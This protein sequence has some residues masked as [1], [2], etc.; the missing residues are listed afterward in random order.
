MATAISKP[1]LPKLLSSSDTEKLRL[2]TLTSQNRKS[3]LTKSLTNSRRPSPPPRRPWIT[4][5][6]ITHLSLIAKTQ[7]LTPPNFSLPEEIQYQLQEEWE[8]IVHDSFERFRKEM[9]CEECGDMIEWCGDEGVKWFLEG[10]RDEMDGWCAWEVDER[11]VE[12]WDGGFEKMVPLLRGR[13]VRGC[14]LLEQ[15]Q[16]Q[17]EEQDHGGVGGEE[18]EGG[19]VGL[20]VEEK[21]EEGNIEGL[22]AL[23]LMGGEGFTAHGFVRHRSPLWGSVVDEPLDEDTAREGSLVGDPGDQNSVNEEFESSVR[24]QESIAEDEEITITAEVEDVQAS[25]S[26]ETFDIKEPSTTIGGQPDQFIIDML[27]AP[28]KDESEDGSSGEIDEADQQSGGD[29]E[30][31]VFADSNTDAESDDESSLF[32]WPSDG[33]EIDEPIEP[34]PMYE[35]KAPGS[36]SQET[37]F[38]GC[39]IEDHQRF[40]LGNTM[41][42]DEPRES[43]SENEADNKEDSDSEDLENDQRETG[44]DVCEDLDQGVEVQGYHEKS[45]DAQ[46]EDGTGICRVVDQGAEEV[47]SVGGDADD[48]ES[49]EVLDDSDS[50]RDIRM[51]ENT[52]INDADTEHEESNEEEYDSQTH[53][54]VLTDGPAKVSSPGDPDSEVEVLVENS[55]GYEYE[56]EQ[57]VPIGYGAQF[58]GVREYQGDESDESEEE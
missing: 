47:E 22:E 17:Q 26:S 46:M 35:V 31:E 58:Q 57:N 40:P 50:D 45:T 15:E 25:P 7:H 16:E 10:L 4:S 28:A 20:G 12:R 9:K 13:Q 39:D 54:D 23:E 56:V 6:T 44:M 42:T 3:K 24:S 1:P 51:G 36:E 19:A 14:W 21:V 53:Q 29:V 5:T 18:G 38:E 37:D 30:M 43:G 41:E 32:E 33:M 34:G 49:D 8:H 2:R 55:S 27:D 11:C 48:E 52:E